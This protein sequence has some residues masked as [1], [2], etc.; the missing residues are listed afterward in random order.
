MAVNLSKSA[1]SLP[2]G[3]PAY[4]PIV[5]VRDVVIFPFTEPVLT[6]GR[7]K[8][9]KAVEQANTSNQ[10]ICLVSQKDAGVSEPMKDDL[11]STGVMVKIEKL[12][13]I[14]GVIHALVKGTTRCR[15]SSVDDSGD[16]WMAQ[17]ETLQDDTSDTEEIEALS[18]HLT[19]LFKKA[20]NLG[21]AVD[22]TVFMRL[23]SGVSASELTDQVASV[24]DISIKEKQEL[25]E[26]LSIKTRLEK[27]I[28]FLSREMKVLELEHSIASK[29][30]KRMDKSMREAILRERK[31]TI[32]S[33]LSA[34]GS[35]DVEDDETGE[36]KKK[37][38]EANMPKDVR[39]KAEK[40]LNRLSSMSP[41]NPESGYLRN[42]LDWL[43]E[44]PWSKSSPSNISLQHAVDILENDH[45][46]LK[47]V[48]E[49]IVEYLAVMQ[50]KQK[51]HQSSKNESK[52]TT[53]NTNK[54]S[55]KKSEAQDEKETAPETGPTILCFVGPPGVGKTSIGRSIAKAL[56][57]EFVRVSLGGVRDE[58][59]I[60]GHRRT[61]VGALPGR[62]VQGIKNADTN[63]P[64]FML[65]EIDKLASDM[66]GDPSSALL[67]ALDPEQNREFSD[68][69]L[70]VPFDL[71]KV[72][73]IA[74]ANLLDT[75]PPA[76]RDRL[77]V[78]TF[79]GYTEAEKYH[80]GQTY[81]WPK[82]KKLHG[83]TD[84][85]SLAKSAFGQIIH[86]YTKEA[87]VRNLERKL[88]TICRKLARQIAEDKSVNKEVTKDMVREFLGPIEFT[89]QLAEKQDEIG[90]AT[91]LAYTPVGG[92]ILF[93]EVAIMPGKGDLTLT[94][95]LGDVMQESCKAAFSYIR[96]RWKELAV[97]H[98]F[99]Q[100]I[101]VHIHVPEGAVPKDGPSAGV[102]IATALTSAI[103]K[104]PSRK[105][106]AM[107]G[108]ITLRGRV[109][110]IGGLKEKV[111]AAHRAGIK[112]VIL[113]KD[114]EKNM[115]DIPEK[116]RE[117]IEFVF[118]N[119]LDEVLP[120]ALTGNL[121]LGKSRKKKT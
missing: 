51:H 98:D 111:I 97:K 11:F 37:I 20:V 88:A 44:M 43:V 102:A 21:K 81:L 48:K 112:T 5:P 54:K 9:I 28:N 60:R 15:I 18:K 78:I 64:V 66:R 56:G 121:E 8:S 30:Q 86:H 114:N 89:S 100:E 26:I 104:K 99:A 39:K 94:G 92:D 73:F 42:Y 71:S 33:E 75:V 40:E 68:H 36:L 106:V 38:K 91:G 108:E 49:R 16:Y 120:V 27:I 41:H 116:V 50:L 29:T 31:K 47:K 103:T 74:T 7:P 117:S 3:D 55:N 72:M 107:T 59:E 115:E 2:S 24:L 23:M 95:Q 70:E 1:N 84:D 101:D 80:I 90:M 14:E 57:R 25:L 62:L 63:N 6:F 118:V 17:V 22:L 34:L 19:G 79:S 12:L 87:G 45:Y 113:P 32:E 69:Y 52:K 46:G 119:H 10:M 13:T 82:Q 85:V 61:Y 35:K 76:L 83:L 77:E 109:T 67:E 53:A 58:A 96:T 105:D 110:E 4:V 65:D 93:I